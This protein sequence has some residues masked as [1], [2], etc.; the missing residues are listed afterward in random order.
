MPSKRHL[1]K[2][3]P[4]CLMAL[5]GGEATSTE[6]IARILESTNQRDRFTESNTAQSLKRL[7]D[8]K[9]VEAIGRQWP[10]SGGRIKRY[11]RLTELGTAEA[12]NQVDTIV[13]FVGA[14]R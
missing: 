12:I 6:L 10:G 8:E 4:A 2:C 14:F 3:R 9:L 11:W 7:R 5:L 1:L 13:Q